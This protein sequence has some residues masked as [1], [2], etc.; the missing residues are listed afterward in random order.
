[1]PLL[2]QY[3]SFATPNTNHDTNKKMA[4][5][6]PIKTLTKFIKKEIYKFWKLNLFF[7]L[8]FSLCHISANTQNLLAK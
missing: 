1:M 7:Q 2:P 3:L 8:F 4:T 5:Q 6:P